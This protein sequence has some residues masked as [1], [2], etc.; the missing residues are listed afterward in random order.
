MIVAMTPQGVIGNRGVMPWR[1]PRD[2]ARFKKFTTRGNTAVV[3]GPKTLE[4][5]GRPLNHRLNIVLTSQQDYQKPGVLVAHDARQCLELAAIHGQREFFVIGGA[6]VYATF[7]PLAAHLFVTYVL[8]E[9]SGDT[10]FPHWNKAEW[11]E[12]YVEKKWRQGAAD[13]HA[14]RFAEY[15]RLLRPP[16]PS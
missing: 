15:G 13:T 6:M 8:S 12:V 11:N 4:S 10:H 16:T 2:M 9:A 14:T 7:F 1:L 5:I 3:M